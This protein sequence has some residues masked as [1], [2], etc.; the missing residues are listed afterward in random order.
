M[1][2]DMLDGAEDCK[3]IYQ[4]LLQICAMYKEIGGDWPSQRPQ[5]SGWL[6]ELS[7]LNP[8][9]KERR[10]GSRRAMAL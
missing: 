1:L 5:M 3:W 7:K 4:S 6:D 9:R 10:V 2:R 8:V